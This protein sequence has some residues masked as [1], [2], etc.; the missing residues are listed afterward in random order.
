MRN[1][2]T[3]YDAGALHEAIRLATS[4]RVIVHNT[5]NSTSLLSHL[6]ARHIRLLSTVAANEISKGTFMF[7]GLGGMSF[8]GDGRMGHMPLLEKAGTSLPTKV[9]D[10]WDQVVY[11]SRPHR[12]RRRD[13]VLGAANQDGGA[14]VDRKLAPTY[15]M[16]QKN[17]LFA[18]QPGK[19]DR[20]VDTIHLM[21]LRQLAY[22]VLS[23]R[24]LLALANE[25]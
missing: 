23:S 14:H 25:A 17:F 3:S 21:G 6:G 2:C 16:L 7:H 13:L 1:S 19:P 10:W 20:V 4:I 22:E 11:V 5:K 9:E 12:V 8:D 24:D 18:V 15:E